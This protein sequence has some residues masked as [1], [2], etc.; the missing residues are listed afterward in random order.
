MIVSVHIDTTLSIP[1]QLAEIER[2]LVS[3]AVVE[4]PPVWYCA[5]CQIDALTRRGWAKHLIS[6]GHTAEAA[7]WDADHAP[8]SVVM[9]PPGVSDA[10]VRAVMG[11]APDTSDAAP[12]APKPARKPRA[13]APAPEVDPLDRAA[14]RA[15]LAAGPQTIAQLRAELLWGD[16]LVHATLDAI[17]AV[18]SGKARGT[19]YSLPPVLDMPAHVDE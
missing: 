3:Q 1:A 2:L 8:A 15:A 14:M 16:D 12:P 13:K 5:T 18:K 11:E 10:T 4:P 7:K 6:V 9:V 19:R 17:G